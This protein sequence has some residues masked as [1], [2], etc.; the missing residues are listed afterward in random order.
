MQFIVRFASYLTGTA[1]LLLLASSLQAAS[2]FRAGVILEY[3]LN[4]DEVLSA[5]EFLQARRA[6]FENT[7]TND[8]GEV[9]IDE[10]VYEWEGHLQQRLEQERKQHVRQ[11]HTRFDAINRDADDYISRAE[12]DASGERGFSYL[13]NDSDGVSDGVILSTDTT[14]DYGRASADTD[15][16]GDKPKLKR[17]ATL[18]M[19][20]THTVKGMLELYDLDGDD[21]VTYDE[22]LEERKLQFTRADQDGNGLIDLQEYL[23]EFED[24]LDAQIEDTYK[25]HIEAA[26]TRFGFL[27]GDKNESMT[28]KEY[29]I[30]GNRIFNRWDTTGDGYMTVSDPMPER[31]WE[32]DFQNDNADQNEAQSAQSG[33]DATNESVAQANR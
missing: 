32:D 33:A 12:F 11:T 28:F 19:P 26:E 15:A 24:R 2:H 3:D 23:V 16:N 31:R 21:Q 13:D 30:S 9:D 22:Y 10:Y 4:G 25:Q 6:R 14:P 5:E 7:D 18:R 1:V 27:D 8:D 20:S 29:M 17:P